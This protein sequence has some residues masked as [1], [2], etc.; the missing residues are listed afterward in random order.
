MILKCAIL[1]CTHNLAG[2]CGAISEADINA[3]GCSG[4][5]PGVA[6]GS[7]FEVCGCGH[8]RAD[9]YQARGACVAMPEGDGLCACNAFR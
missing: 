7:P 6:P 1:V 2:S 4:F 5:K 9:H 3:S 8:L